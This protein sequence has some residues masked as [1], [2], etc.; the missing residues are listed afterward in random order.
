[1]ERC[2]DLLSSDEIQ[3]IH[4]ASLEVLES[5]GLRLNHPVA[6]EKLSA[7]GAK[8]DKA[9]EQVCLPPN[10]VEEALETAPKTFVCA[11]RDLEFDLLMSPGSMAM[12]FVRS[13]TG[14]ISY[15]DLIQNKYRPITVQDC[16]DIAQLMDGLNN[17][18]IV[19]CLVPEDA[20]KRTY[21]LHALKIMLEAGRKHIWALPKDS[22]NLK[23]QLEMMKAVAGGTE[24]LRKRPICSGIVCLIEPLHF[25]S[26]EIERL[27]L[28]G[29]CNLPVKVP[30]VPMF[31]ANAPYT[32]AGALTHTNAEALGSLVLLQ[33]LC[34]GIPT[35][36]YM[37]LSEMDM[38]KG[39]ANYL[40]PEIMLIYSGLIQLARHYNIPSSSLPFTT[41]DCQIHQI[42]FERGTALIMYALSGTTE[43]GGAGSVDGAIAIS[44]LLLVL[45]DEMA[46]YTRRIMEGIAI[47]RERLAVEAI[48]RVGHRGSF[49]EDPH[50]LQFLRQ[51]R[52]FK[53]TIFDWRSFETW[54][55]DGNTIVER[56]HDKM[57]KILST[58][59]VP[60]LDEAIQRELDRI[61]HAAEKE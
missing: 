49:L 27:L 19:G 32:L 6:L 47:D 26:D 1:M 17:M 58:H 16:H 46:A 59:E 43:V 24:A 29:E 45:D 57:N 13:A 8:V 53:P 9:K 21:D 10:M 5:T 55:R 42:M 33:T 34:P 60:P 56:A 61:I 11:G 39:T 50:T 52:H 51:E 22:K 20:P 2:Y 38:A 44:P 25:P 41:T 15:Y 54:N 48:N 7:A 35:W 28:Y 18:N 4:E 30:L 14:S 36:Y 3:M 40:N 31:G 23:Y 12:P 37:L